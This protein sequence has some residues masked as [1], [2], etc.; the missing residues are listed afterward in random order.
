MNLIVNKLKER[1]KNKKSKYNKSTVFL[2]P[3]LADKEFINSNFDKLINIYYH[4]EK[5]IDY[6]K[7]YKDRIYLVFSNKDS[8]VKTETLKESIDFLF[9]ET[10]D[11]YD[12][13]TF[14]IPHQY[15]TDYIKFK[16]GLYTEISTKYKNML[17]AYYPKNRQYL[18][19]ILY[20]T[21]EDK[22][23][24]GLFLNS[25]EKIKEVYSSPDNEEEIFKASKFY[26]LKK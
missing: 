2:L 16:K 10:I 22:K 11:D 1:Y 18:N 13:Y 23:Q 20:P 24:L 8:L 12:V 21:D 17:L 19:S 9:S 5:D 25:N 4:T 15:L 6:N 14:K 7:N 3:M 26:K